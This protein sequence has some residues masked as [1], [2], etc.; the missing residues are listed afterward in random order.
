[1]EAQYIISQYIFCLRLLIGTLSEKSMHINWKKMATMGKHFQAEKLQW[2]G[3]I[4]P[5]G[6]FPLHHIPIGLFPLLS[7]SEALQAFTSSFHLD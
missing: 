4:L 6:H 5:E 1:M 7:L 2:G 3:V